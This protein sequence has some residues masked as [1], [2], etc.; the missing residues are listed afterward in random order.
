MEL[1]QKYKIKELDITKVG[2]DRYMEDTK[3]KIVDY[4]LGK[5][6]EQKIRRFYESWI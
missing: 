6:N 5:N 1:A 3:Q 2:I 4:E